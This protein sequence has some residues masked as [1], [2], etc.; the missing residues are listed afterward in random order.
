MKAEQ[1]RAQH[2]VSLLGER[3]G[4]FICN[5]VMVFHSAAE[6]SFG[7][8]MT[9]DVECCKLE[10]GGEAGG[11]LKAGWSCGLCK[12]QRREEKFLDTGGPLFIFPTDNGVT[13][14][15]FMC[16]AE[17]QNDGMN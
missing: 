1:R 8:L 14:C 15:I 12:R 10:R 5:D 7:L 17:N 9:S 4:L 3:K 16:V 2:N 11:S 6:G 13:F